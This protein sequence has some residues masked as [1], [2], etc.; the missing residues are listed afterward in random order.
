MKKR[1]R[2]IILFTLTICLAFS[3]PGCKEHAVQVAGVNAGD[4]DTAL[5]IHPDHIIFL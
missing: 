4:V 2:N 1:I 5:M 3:T